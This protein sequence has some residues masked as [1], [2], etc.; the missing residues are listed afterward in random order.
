MPTKKSKKVVLKKAATNRPARNVIVKKRS[1]K[2]PDNKEVA[3][4]IVTRPNVRSIADDILEKTVLQKQ[5]AARRSLKVADLEKKFKEAGLTPTV[6]IKD[7]LPTI[8]KISPNALLPLEKLPDDIRKST[9]ALKPSTKRFHGSKFNLGYF[10]FPSVKSPCADRFG[11]LSPTTVRTASQ[12]PFNPIM[13]GLL[14]KLGNLM[15]NTPG[16]GTPSPIPA[17]YTYFGQFVDHDITL[18]V[19]SNLETATDAN[20][21]NN[22]RSPSLDLDSVYG[23]GPALDS[24]LYSFP[25]T[26]PSTAIKLVLGFN[27]KNG[28]GGPGG[29]GGIGN[30]QE[31]IDFDV[32]RINNPLDPGADTKTAIIG[33]PRNDENLI[34]VQF[35]HTMLKFHN[36]VVDMLVVAGFS[37]D[38]FLEAK[39]IVTH[40]YQWAVVHDFLKRVCGTSAVTNALSTVVALPGSP[41]RMPVEFAV[42]AY[43]FGH[44]MIRNNYWVNFNFP[45]A[46]LSDIF[47]FNRKPNL[48]VQSIWV[49]DFNAF[50]PTG[51]PVPVFNNA[52]KIDSL[53]AKELENL[54]GGSG[55]MAVLA[56]R[57]LR[58][59]LALGLPS[60]QALAGHFGL[61]ILTTPQLIQ[62]LS[63]E[64]VS[65]LK[66]SGSILLKKTPLW[67][68]VLREA[69]IF[70]GGDRLGPL[71]AKIVAETFV[72]ILKRD[73]TSFWNVGPFTPFLPS[74]S[75]GS[76]T[77]TDLVVFAGVNLP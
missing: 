60:G 65:V 50:F 21:I 72:R 45:F 73:A 77:V 8:N 47:K 18:D 58:R 10:P 36:A 74:A 35:H 56:S 43:R 7:L 51:V 14:E 61:P 37:G 62:G 4:S 5:P 57:N 38:I 11:Y 39:K 9:Q 33:D 67:Y 55:I 19:S 53:L 27:T 23:R 63:A 76:F 70:Q 2:L 28:K 48:P 13:Q 71:G 46:P 75:P 22:M 42:A 6:P 68:Y 16:D 29:P 3:N 69:M 26:G 20:A 32:P 41:F 31:Q 40:H 17:G 25:S 34:V 66:E 15:G 54:P 52:Q 44:S 30:M 59:G 64:E 1:K 12:L 24:Y 49:V